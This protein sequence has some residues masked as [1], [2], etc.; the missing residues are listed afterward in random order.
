MVATTVAAT[1]AA[2]V[3]AEMV[4]EMGAGSAGTA[5]RNSWRALGPGRQA[6]HGVGELKDSFDI[7]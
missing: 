5:V 4:A 1:L 7:E 2:M 6:K 3:G